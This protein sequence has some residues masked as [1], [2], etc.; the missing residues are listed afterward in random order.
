V[1]NDY[2]RSRTERRRSWYG[3][4]APV[5]RMLSWR[6]PHAVLRAVVGR[7]PAL[8]RLGRLPAPAA[9]AEVEGEA[10]GHRFVML[11]PDRC[12]IAKELYWGKGRR[13]RP[14][15]AL[16][17]D[18]F[19]RLAG[20]SDALLDIGAYT[21]IF[22]LVGTAVSETVRAHAFEIVPHVF[23]AL[24]ANCVRN[25]VLHRATLHHVGI[26]APG[27]SMRVPTGSG[28]SALPSYYSRS[29]HFEGGVLVE[30]VSLDSLIPLVPAA[31]RVVAK[32]D[33]EGTEHE[34]FRHGQSFLTAYR[35]DV[36]CEVLAEVA[37]H[38]ELEGLLPS[39]YF[40]YL[41][42]EESLSHRG[43]IEPDPRFRDW[44]FTPRS[45]D[46]L[47]SLGVPIAGSQGQ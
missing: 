5:K 2:R 4:K 34:I 33:V 45:P 20:Q 10:L 41:I 23:Q 37:H 46:E 1:G 3:L 28:G 32:I 43:R 29:L 11:R 21:G 44:L 6:I 16:A 25:D 9:L 40:R 8:A 26:G 42:V 12:E 7:W 24:F 13:P 27:D 17:I 47:A 39:G 30:F 15:D 22:T 36:I 31:A 14:E 19:A 18:V 35:P 38:D